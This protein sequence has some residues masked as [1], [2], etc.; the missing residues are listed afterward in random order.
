ML[1]RS[2]L[3]FVTLFAAPALA[4]DWVVLKGA[5]IERALDDRSVIYEAARQ[6]FYASGRTLYDNGRPSWGY[7]AVRGDQYCSQWPPADGW[8]C[9]DLAVTPDGSGVKFI[10]QTGYET[11]GLFEE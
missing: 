10:S 5:R 8:A 4:Q 11:K 1:A 9:Y 6:K 3:G 2:L 7:W